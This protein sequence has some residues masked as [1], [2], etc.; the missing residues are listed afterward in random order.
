MKQLLY[1][2]AL[3]GLASCIDIDEHADNPRGN[4]DAL[5]TILDEH[6]CFFEQKGIDWQA[7]HDEYA[8]RTDPQ[9]TS[10]QLFEV[11]ADMLATLRDGHVNLSATADFA[12]YW[13]WK[14]DF[15]AN[16]S[17][18]LLRRYLGT[19]YKIAGPLR[20]RILSDNIGYVRLATFDTPIGEGNIDAVL[21]HLML[22]RGMI[23]DI[24]D[25]GGGMLTQAERLAAR[26]ADK[27]TLVGYFRHKTGPGHGEFSEP[28]EQ[29]LGPS[30]N[31]RWTKPTVV[32]TNRGVFSAA[33]EFTKYMKRMPAV[34]IVGDRTGGGAGMP[35][36]SSLPNG[37]A[38][39]FSAC[40]MTDADGKST[41]DGIE[42]DIHAAI[43]NSLTTDGIIEKAREV[44]AGW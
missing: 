30:S 10:D 24:R 2:L 22:C 20:Y 21:N 7:V 36:S 15:P 11:C 28:E 25:N 35:F 13:K 9:M 26:F 40:P 17:D 44:I 14:E 6:Y 27:S 3:L 18:T 5:W 12:R 38:V 23:I 33:N 41:E 29:W 42:P 34:K 1:A 8:R 31:L 39:R 43:G 37:W 4:L 16:V 19:D 32:L